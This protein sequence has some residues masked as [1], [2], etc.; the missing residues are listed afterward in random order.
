MKNIIRQGTKC[1]QVALPNVGFVLLFKAVDVDGAIV[2]LEENDRPRPAG[3]T[4][5]S[6]RNALLD[7]ATTEIGVDSALVTLDRDGMAW[8]DAAGNSGLFP[9]RP[10][11][12]CDITGAG[13]MVLAALGYTIAAGGDYAAAIEVANT[14]GGLEVERLG[15][16]PLTRQEIIDELSHSVPGTETGHKILSIE[17]MESQLRRL[18]QAGQRVVMTNGC[19]DLLHPGH[20][21]ALE[22]DAISRV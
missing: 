20:V 6:T 5:P 2:L 13:D 3:L 1:H 18:R 14:A 15:V 12:V 9:A 17:Q 10:R 22:E 16:V 7:H 21:A 11:Q 19:F 8:A 4:F